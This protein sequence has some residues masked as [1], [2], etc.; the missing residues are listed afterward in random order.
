MNRLFFDKFARFFCFVIGVG[1]LLTSGCTALKQSPSVGKNKWDWNL[2]SADKPN[3]ADSPLYASSANKKSSWLP[4][5]KMP[6]SSKQP[7]SSYSRNNNSTW[8]RMKKSSKRFWAKTAEV[9]DP[10]PDPKPPT[11]EP[12]KDSGFFSWFKRDEPKQVKTVGDFLSQ[13]RVGS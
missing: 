10:Y 13:P 11:S 6:W 2:F 12:K 4:S 3:P 5:W 8:D 1:V 7:S 9:L